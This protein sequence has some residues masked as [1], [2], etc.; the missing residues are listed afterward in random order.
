MQGVWRHEI[1]GSE[2]HVTIHP[3]G[4]LPVWAKKAAGEEAE[5]LAAFLG[6]KPRLAWKE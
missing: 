5:R 2:T 6:D 3:F 4:E 1:K